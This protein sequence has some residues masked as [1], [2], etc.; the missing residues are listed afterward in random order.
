LVT[1]LIQRIPPVPPV[2]PFEEDKLAD[3]VARHNL[4]TYG[5]SYDPVEL[6]EW[7]RGMKNIF[8]MFEVPEENRE[9]IRTFY[10]TGEVD[11]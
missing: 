1:E 11:I 5:E 6:K 3:R 7:I 2:N 10:L 9:N 8:A 4:K